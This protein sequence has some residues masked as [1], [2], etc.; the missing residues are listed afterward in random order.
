MLLYKTKY[1]LGHPQNYLFLLSK[2]IFSGSKYPKKTS[3]HF[4]NRSTGWLSLTCIERSVMRNRNFA[5]ADERRKVLA[6]S[7]RSAPA[8]GAGESSPPLLASPTTPPDNEP[9]STLSP[10]AASNASVSSTSEVFEVFAE[11]ARYSRW[12]CLWQ[13]PTPSQQLHTPA[14]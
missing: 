11:G 7:S 2:K 4:E 9:T 14:V 6:H 10:V 13:G 5:N 8:L 1:R 3:F 12:R